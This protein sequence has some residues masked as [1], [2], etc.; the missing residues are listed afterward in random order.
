MP[1][2]HDY[3]TATMSLPDGHFIMDKDLTKEFIGDGDS[4]VGAYRSD[5]A[6]LLKSSM[7]RGGT[8]PICAA[9]GGAG[10]RC[11]HSNA[12][13]RLGTRPHFDVSLPLL[14][15][16]WL[17]VNRQKHFDDLDLGTLM[18]KPRPILAFFQG[19]L[20]G[21]GLARNEMRKYNDP[22]N[23]FIISDTTH[24]WKNKRYK[25]P[26]DYDE[27]LAK[28]KF[29]FAPAGNGQHSFRLGEVMKAGAVPIDV[30]RQ[31][32]GMVLPFEDV[33]D[34][35][36]FSIS[37]GLTELPMLQETLRS[38]SEAEFRRMQARSLSVARIFFTRKHWMTIALDV[39][40]RN[41]QVAVEQSICS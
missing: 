35:T 10:G 17:H 32:G 15:D 16:P 23:G 29:G 41:V 8:L 37:A 40:R 21:D 3:D 11:L 19:R 25:D 22:S 27:T 28:A 38:I 26:Y 34:W 4:L 33:L 6:L 7:P 36:K 39:V 31:K 5:M 14:L 30:Q 24:D 9:G 18:I 13:V 12:D 20:Q 2:F 1:D